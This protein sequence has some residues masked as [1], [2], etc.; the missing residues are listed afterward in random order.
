[1]RVIN[2]LKFGTTPKIAGIPWFTVRLRKMGAGAKRAHN[3]NQENQWFDGGSM[4]LFWRLGGALLVGKRHGGKIRDPKVP[5]S[6]CHCRLGEALVRLDPWPVAPA[7]FQ[8]LGSS[9]RQVLL[10]PIPGQ[11]FA[12]S[13]TSAS[14]RPRPFEREVVPEFNSGEGRGTR[15]VSHKMQG[16]DGPF[17]S[18]C[19]SSVA[20]CFNHGWL[21]CIYIYIYVYIYIYI[22]IFVFLRVPLFVLF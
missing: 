4:L 12:L 5:F 8:F 18:F 21:I 15:E 2:S 11:G 22:Y 9:S 16:E 10:S 17:V 6:A 20:T 1:M 19:P 7:R 13:E 14:C 3:S